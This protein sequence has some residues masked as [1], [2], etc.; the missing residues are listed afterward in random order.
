MSRVRDQLVSV[1]FILPALLLL[2]LFLVYPTIVTFRMSLDTGA[3]L[4]IT[5]FVGLD[6]YRR[7]AGDRLFIDIA[8][9]SG[10]VFNNLLW[11][12]VYVG[13]CLAF[14]LLIAA[15][16]DKVRYEGLIKTIV[17]APQA[18]AATAAGVIWLLVYAPQPQIGI[19]NG[20]V[21]ALGG[22][23][24]GWLGL[25]Q[26]VN[27]AIIVAAVWAGT[28]LAVVILSAA[29][30]GVP[31]E[32]V[33]AA[34]LDGASSRQSFRYVVL[35]MISTPLSVVAVTLG[36]AVIKLFDIVYVMTDGGPAGASRVIGYFYYQQTFEA[37]RGGYGAAA[38]MVMVLLMVPIMAL[39]IRRFRAEEADR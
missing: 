23:P 3:G 17:F 16:A 9:L 37:G 31:A 5:E 29:I 26:T 14:G 2:L 6:N 27:L 21:A 15:L 28:G 20:A 8:H 19:L 35:P 13:G 12:V 25:R 36:I 39:N 10:A 30:K 7:L 38:A 32:L 1:L 4:R 34:M 11:L 18:I 24:I 22:S 33:E